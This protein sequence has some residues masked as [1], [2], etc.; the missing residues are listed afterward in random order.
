MYARK[1]TQPT[2]ACMHAH[3]YFQTKAILRN[4]ACA[5][6]TTY[7]AKCVYLES[8]EQATISVLIFLNCLTLSLNAMISVGH[9]NVLEKKI[10]AMAIKSYVMH[11]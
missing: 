5:L 10:F 9:T 11:L 2:H 8:T 3:K 1:H 6:S 4:K 7:H